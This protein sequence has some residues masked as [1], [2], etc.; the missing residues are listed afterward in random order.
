MIPKQLII[1][2]EYGVFGIHGFGL[3]FKI[4]CIC[5]RPSRVLENGRTDETVVTTNAGYH[6][7]SLSLDDLFSSPDFRT[8][9]RPLAVSNRC[10][11]L[12]T[13]DT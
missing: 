2:T 10:R 1:R 5:V 9:C 13:R 11:V 6:I 8:R 4:N 7:R 12:L 3:K